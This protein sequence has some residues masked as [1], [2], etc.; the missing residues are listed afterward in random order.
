MTDSIAFT[1]VECYQP[2][3]SIGDVLSSEDKRIATDPH[4]MQDPTRVTEA[5]IKKDFQSF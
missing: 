5:G 3:V 2:V 4:L 1:S